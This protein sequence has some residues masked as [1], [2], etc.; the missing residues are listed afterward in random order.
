MVAETMTELDFRQFDHPASSPDLELWNFVLFGCLHEK[1]V[2]PVRETVEELEEKSRMLIAPD[3]NR[4][5]MKS[6]RISHC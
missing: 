2:W 5:G 1:M 3:C 6:F 4:T